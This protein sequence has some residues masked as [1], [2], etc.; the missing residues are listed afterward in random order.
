MLVTQ[1]VRQTSSPPLLRCHFHVDTRIVKFTC[2]VTVTD[3]IITILQKFVKC[4]ESARGGAELQPAKSSLETHAVGGGNDALLVFISSLRSTC[5][6]SC[7]ARWRKYSLL[8]PGTTTA[9]RTRASCSIYAVSSVIDSRPRRLTSA[10]TLAVSGWRRGS[11]MNARCRCLWRNRCRMMDGHWALSGQNI[12]GRLMRTDR[13][14]QLRNVG[15]GDTWRWK[16][17]YWHC[18]CCLIHAADEQ[19]NIDVAVTNEELKDLQH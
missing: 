5:L 10:R 17:R 11:D 4:G 13:R 7:R 8:S 6:E 16:N 14:Q 19:F 15:Q 18:T 9:G 12:R 2:S 3:C 1:K